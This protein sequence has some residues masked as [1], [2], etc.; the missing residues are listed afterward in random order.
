MS[1]EMLE[2]LDNNVIIEWI[3]IPKSSDNVLL[4]FDINSDTVDCNL[5]QNES[6]LK[7]ETNS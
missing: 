7:L 1:Y 6:K 4:E 3:V 5:I 2:V